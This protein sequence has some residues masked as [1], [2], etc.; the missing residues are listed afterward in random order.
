MRTPRVGVIGTG[1]MGAHHARAFFALRHLCDFVGIYDTRTNVAE[2]V[3]KAYGVKA[4]DSLSALLES[5][6]AVS[7]AVP[8]SLHHQ[9][10]SECLRRGID[11]LLEKPI[12][13]TLA[14]ADA[15]IRLA[16]RHRRILQIGHIERF[17]PAIQELKKI[18]SAEET[19]GLQVERLSP[20]DPRVKDTDVIADLMI[21]DLD[22]ARYLLPGGLLSVQALGASCVSGLID[23]AVA[24]F[25]TDCGTVIN[26]TA[27]RVT[28]GKVRRM[29]VT[30]R[31]AFIELDYMDRKIAIARR[32]GYIVGSGITPVYRQ[33]NIVERVFVPATEPLI[34]QTES[35]LAAV[36]G[37]SAPP[38]SGEDGREALRWAEEIRGQVWG[39][40]GKVRCGHT[41]KSRIKAL[42]S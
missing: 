2:E 41:A 33:E 26:L 21:H 38:V 15:L 23:Y 20:Y 6:D 19:I 32:T 22:V 30:T 13:G 3:A 5:V 11:V 24:T 27:S 8:T 40:L 29:T 14:E 36:K 39:E 31:Q 35:F 1:S 16:R 25:L 10:A 34:A 18:L 42:G 12:A 37:L 17:N 28:E 7:V 4:F 9:V